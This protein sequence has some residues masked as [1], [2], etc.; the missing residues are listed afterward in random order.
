MPQNQADLARRPGGP[1]LDEESAGSRD[2][3]PAPAECYEFSASRWERDRDKRVRCR[4][5]DGN[6]IGSW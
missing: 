3:S 1:A 6:A 2:A 5:S 4:M